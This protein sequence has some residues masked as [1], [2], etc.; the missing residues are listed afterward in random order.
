MGEMCANCDHAVEDHEMYGDLNCN[1][2]G[3][4]CIEFEEYDE[5]EDE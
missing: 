5:E 2:E 3:C 4:E 1:V